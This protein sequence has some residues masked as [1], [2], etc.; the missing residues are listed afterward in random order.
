MKSKFVTTERQRLIVRI[1]SQGKYKV[2]IHTGTVSKKIGTAWRE[3][4]HSVGGNATQYNITGIGVSI[5]VYGQTI[6]WLAANGEYP[7]GQYIYHKDG[8]KSHNAISNLVLGK[9]TVDPQ[10]KE[11]VHDDV[12][13]AKYTRLVRNTEI[14]KIK[15]FL[16]KDPKLTAKEIAHMLRCKYSS[17]KYAVRAIKYGNALK[18]DGPGP[19]SGRM[20]KTRQWIT[21]MNNA[22]Y[23]IR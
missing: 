14:Q 23:H 12:F 3:L 2:S 1:L 7:E 15:N 13:L 5:K 4:K 18:F 10:V 8:N 19:Y 9:S 20:T 17:V 6:V 21:N 11:Q 22:D 16:A